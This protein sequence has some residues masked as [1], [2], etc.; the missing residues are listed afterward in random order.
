[1]LEVAPKLNCAND[2]YVSGRLFDPVVRSITPH[3]FLKHTSTCINC[4]KRKAA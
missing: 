2:V 4:M 1:M 3:S